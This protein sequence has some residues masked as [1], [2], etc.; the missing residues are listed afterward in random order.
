MKILKFTFILFGVLL[1]LT[2]SAQE[3]PKNLDAGS[4]SKFKVSIG[5][6]TA[7]YYG[8]LIKKDIGFTQPCFSFSAGMS[9]A[10]TGNFAAR[11]DVGIQKLQGSDGKKGGAHPGR[12]LSFKSNVIDF[13]IAGE[14]TILNLDKFP[15]SPYV[16]AGVGVL[17][18]NPYS[19][20]AS[21]N[22]QAL[23]ELGTEGQGLAGYPGFYNTAALEFPLGVGLKH[24]ISNN[25]TLG[26]EFNYRITRTDYLDDVSRVG[27]PDKALLD[28]RNPVTAN[29]TWRSNEVGGGAYPKTTTLPRGN[30]DN[31][32]GFFTTQLKLTF[33]L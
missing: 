1:I 5:A 4:D 22:K 14:Y 21:G 15:I 31:N 20:D 17:F 7:N 10:I 23:P 29:F 30:P 18:F 6:G 32:D 24:K 12:N 26:L 19:E 3:S 28:A 11:L 13:S 9:Y 8:D 2:A 16:S 27:Y 33:K 25:V